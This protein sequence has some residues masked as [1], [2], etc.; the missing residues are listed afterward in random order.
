MK[1]ARAPELFFAPKKQRA[2]PHTFVLDALAPLDPYT[3]PMFGCTA[4]YV[5][6]KIVLILRDKPAPAADNGVWVAT[7]VEHHESLRGE[8]PSLRSIS[9][10]GDGVTGWQILPAELPDFEDEALRAVELVLA[11]DPRI[12]KVP[13]AKRPKK[14]A[15]VKQAPAKP[16]AKKKA[17]SKTA[18][19]K[20][21][22]SKTAAKKKAPAKPAAKKKARS[23]SRG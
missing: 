18:A 7:T 5:E 15:P 21:A 9:V 23:R 16:A 1:K 4:V 6:D 13:K 20:K 8:L 12:G 17:P 22:P 2:L 3:R 14:V 11:G 19:K 10:L